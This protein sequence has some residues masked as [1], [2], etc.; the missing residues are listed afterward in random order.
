MKKYFFMIAIV[1]TTLVYGLDFERESALQNACDR[2]DA[3][4][5]VALGAMYHS[6]DGVLQSFSRAK[7]LYTRA[8]ELGL[9]LGCA[10]V[11]YMY[12]SGHAGKN[13]SLALQWYERACILGDGEGCASVALMYENG[14]GVGEDLQQAVDYHDRACNYG[15]GSSCDYLALRYEQDENFVDA[16]IYYQRACDV[17]VA[18]ACSRL[19]E[20]YYYGQ[21][22]SQN[23][24][25]AFEAFKNACELG[26]VSGCKNAEIVKANQRWY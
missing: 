7:A 24:K 12:E 5:C 23:E 1:M 3:K 20:M 11:G 6:G 22:V 19:G 8:C 14:A 15:V 13:L 21:G 16:A 17:G 18:H 4:A 26:E 9:G 10:N 25:K 2:G